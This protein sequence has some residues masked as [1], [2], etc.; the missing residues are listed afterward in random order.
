MALRGEI[1]RKFKHKRGLLILEIL[2]HIFSEGKKG[3]FHKMIVF[4]GKVS[5]FKLY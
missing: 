2:V 5:N 4:I 3:G 1:L